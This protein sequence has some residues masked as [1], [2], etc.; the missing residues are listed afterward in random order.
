[1]LQL[2]DRPAPQHAA[3]LRPCHATLDEPEFKELLAQMK[4]A[5]GSQRARD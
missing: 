1:V 3:R 4:R 2:G 5:V